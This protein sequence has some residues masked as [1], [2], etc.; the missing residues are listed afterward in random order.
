MTGRKNRDRELLKNLRMFYV[1]EQ[2]RY[3]LK[4]TCKQNCYVNFESIARKYYYSYT[5]KM[6]SSVLHSKHFTIRH[7]S[8]RVQIQKEMI[9][10]LK[11]ENQFLS[12]ELWEFIYIIDLKN[13]IC[14]PEIKLDFTA[15][16]INGVPL[17]SHVRTKKWVSPKNTYKI[18]RL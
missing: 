15:H 18:A 2:R 6:N 5:A 3:C 16:G 14:K 4:C 17:V 11:R 1:A 7:E 12:K 8:H 10:D 9:S 13:E